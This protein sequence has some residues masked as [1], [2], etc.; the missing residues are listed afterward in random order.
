M[1][2]AT[3]GVVAA[4]REGRAA[5]LPCRPSAEG[6]VASAGVGYLAH[7][8]DGALELCRED[9]CQPRLGQAVVAALDDADEGVA[10]LSERVLRGFRRAVGR[11]CARR[12]LLACASDD[13]EAPEAVHRYLR[14]GFALGREVFSRPCDGRLVVVDDLA[15]RVLSEAE[16]TRQFAR[17]SRRRDGSW[18]AAVEPA[19]NTV[20]LVAAHFARRMGPERFCL[21]DPGHRVAAFH[22]ARAQGCGVVRLDE[23]L[24]RQLADLGEGDLSSDERYVRALWKRF[25]DRVSL[26]GRGPGERGY[27]LRTAFVPARYRGRLV[28]LDPRSDDAGGLVPERYAGGPATG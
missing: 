11:E 4:V 19:A 10:A 14:L 28:E 9:A 18:I 25:Y 7:A 15:R 27:D 3:G 17:F 16:H 20:P 2:R 21:V 1:E 12:A 8:T 26:P 13:P 22:E 6:I 23:R 24:S 5:L